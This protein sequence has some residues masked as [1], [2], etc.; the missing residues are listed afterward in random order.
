[1][2]I[3]FRPDNGNRH[4]FTNYKT[5][6]RITLVALPES[7]M[8]RLHDSSASYDASIFEWEHLG[9]RCE[10]LEGWTHPIPTAALW[11][12]ELEFDESFRLKNGCIYT[13]GQV[14]HVGLGKTLARKDCTLHFD[15]P[16][17]LALG[18]QHY[19]IPESVAQL[20]YPEVKP[21]KNGD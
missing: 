1:M 2:S 11:A 16:P 19:F 3:L 15:A 9:G 20:P 10:T 21:I 14:Q 18:L 6:K 17:L 7:E 13:V 8:Q 12:V 5:Y 4:S